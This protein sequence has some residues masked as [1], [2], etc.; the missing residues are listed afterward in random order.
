MLLKGREED[1]PRRAVVLHLSLLIH[2]VLIVCSSRDMWG[3]EGGRADVKDSY[4][5]PSSNVSNLTMHP[6]KEED[7]GRATVRHAST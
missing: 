7:I 6:G 2:A 4:I 3:L 1:G 5:I